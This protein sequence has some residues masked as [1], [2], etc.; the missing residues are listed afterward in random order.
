MGVYSQKL[1]N[2]HTSLLHHG[3]KRSFKSIRAHIY[4]G[5]KRKKLV[6]ITYL[7]FFSKTF[8][9]SAPAYCITAL[10]GVLKMFRAH[11]YDYIVMK[12]LVIK[13]YLSFFSKT[14][15]SNTPAYYVALWMRVFKGFRAHV[16]DGIKMKSLLINTVFSWKLSQRAHHLTT[17][18]YDWECIKVLEQIC[19]MV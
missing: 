17:L 10:T 8:L 6:S 18:L 2:K 12:S 11:V 3:T 5:I 15:S 19:I 9:T 14:F 4:D 1:S 13:T 7:S 16:H